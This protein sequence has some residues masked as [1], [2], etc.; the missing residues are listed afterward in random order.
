MLLVDGGRDVVESTRLLL[1]QTDL[2][3][4]GDPGGENLPPV[5]RPAELGGCDEDPVV[6]TQRR[7]GIDEWL[8]R[9]PGPHDEADLQRLSAA[10]AGRPPRGS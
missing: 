5:V 3:D 4:D 9:A 10:S 8:R 6:V 2:D 1:T 7:E